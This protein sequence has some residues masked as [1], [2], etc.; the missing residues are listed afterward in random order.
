MTYGTFSVEIPKP[1]FEVSV[2]YDLD[3]TAEGEPGWIAKVEA[4]GVVLMERRYTSEWILG[5]IYPFAETQE[6]AA[7]K[8]SAEF[9]RKLKVLFELP[10]EES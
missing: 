5:Q 2:E 9:G 7:D 3:A 1:V 4:G 10:G 6:D 8:I